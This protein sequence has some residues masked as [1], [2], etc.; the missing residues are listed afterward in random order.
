MPFLSKLTSMT[1]HTANIRAKYDICDFPRAGV[2]RYA[3]T[4]SIDQANHEANYETY[5]KGNS[6]SQVCAQWVHIA[7]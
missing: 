7:A 4:I 3:I 5:H 6:E 1:L 2:S